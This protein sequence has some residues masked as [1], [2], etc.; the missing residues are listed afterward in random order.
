MR[1]SFLSIKRHESIAMPVFASV[2]LIKLNAFMKPFF[3]N[4]P[5]FDKTANL[6]FDGRSQFL[7]VT[8]YPLVLADTAASAG[9]VFGLKFSGHNSPR[10]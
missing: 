2:G 10:V 7:I 9:T 1:V 6:I 3:D 8:G 5:E 4:P